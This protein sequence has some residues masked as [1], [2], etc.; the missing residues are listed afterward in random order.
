MKRLHDIVGL[1]LEDALVDPDQVV[2]GLRAHLITFHH[3]L[4]TS[5]RH[6]KPANNPISLLLC[7]NKRLQARGEVMHV[8]K[9]AREQ[10]RG[11]LTAA[12]CHQ[13]TLAFARE[14]SAGL[15]SLLLR[16][17]IKHVEQPQLL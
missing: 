14:W 2:A 10:L 6:I 9:V 13:Q 7:V 3:R 5:T 11:Y 12:D 8:F 4:H 1:I 15:A 16:L 17:V